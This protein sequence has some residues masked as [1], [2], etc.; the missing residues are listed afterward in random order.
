VVFASSLAPPLEARFPG[1]GIDVWCKTYTADVA[2]L[3]PHVNDVIASDPFWDRAPGKGKGALRP[4]LDAVR[5]VRNNRYD[6]AILAAAP[7]RTAAAVA[8]AR[9]PMRVG[10]ARRKNRVFLTRVLAGED[11]NRPVLA[12]MA[13]V[14]EPFGIVSPSPRYRLDASSL[15]P[16]VTRLQSVFGAGHGARLLALHPFASKRNRCVA[17]AVWRSVASA[18]ANRGYTIVWIGGS[19]ELDELRSLGE[20]PASRYIDRIGDGSLADTAAVLSM[21]SLFA[22]HDS[23]PLHIAGAFGV[24]VLGVFAPGEP[25][26]TFPQGI[27]EWRMIAKASPLDVS[28]NEIIDELLS[29]PPLFTRAS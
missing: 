14:L 23:G 19:V 21:A 16:R 4:F 13:R 8:A 28:A 20:D 3:I 5:R 7:W 17:L 1:A 27:G 24:P 2:R 25:R 26:R 12:E 10:L 29:L 9:I 11:V 15:A 18:M 22:G 6:A